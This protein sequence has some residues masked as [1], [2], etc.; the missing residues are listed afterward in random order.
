[1][2]ASFGVEDIFRG[3]LKPQFRFGGFRPFSPHLA[4]FFDGADLVGRKLDLH[5]QFVMLL[6]PEIATAL[7]KLLDLVLWRQ[8]VRSLQTHGTP[9][10][11]PGFSI[12][13]E[14]H[15]LPNFQTPIS[16]QTLIF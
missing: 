16:A 11:I 12:P 9:P 15:K 8:I 1:V 14:E 3:L 5:F 7:Q 4:T 2:S 6:F 10:W 13:T